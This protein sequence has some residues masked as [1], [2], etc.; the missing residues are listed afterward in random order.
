MFPGHIR[1][2]IRTGDCVRPCSRFRGEPSA[3]QTR[4][5]FERSCRRPADLGSSFPALL[6]LALDLAPI[7]PNLVARP[8]M[9][10]QALARRAVLDAIFEREQHAAHIVGLHESF[11][12]NLPIIDGEDT[13]SPS[14]SAISFL[15]RN[16]DGRSSTT[17]LSGGLPLISPRSVRRWIASC[18]RA[19]G[20][21][22]TFTCWSSIRHQFQS[23]GW[24]TR[25]RGRRAG[26]SG[27]RA[28]TLPVA[29]GKASFG[30]R[31]TSPPVLAERRLTSLSDMWRRNALPP[32]PEGRGFRARW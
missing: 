7:V 2:H 17:T 11:K 32:R 31:L 12:W 1:K 6:G 30:R 8:R 16:I 10:V 3:C 26:Y 13:L 18:S 9:A 15:L 14:W 29:T 24:S 21:P 20:R 22:T 23:P 27:S 5:Q 28:Q 4:R 19:M 25:S